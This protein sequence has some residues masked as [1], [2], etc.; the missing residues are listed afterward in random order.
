MA[1]LADATIIVEAGE[2]SGTRHQ[3]WEAIRLG[4]PVLFPKGFL[5]PSAPSWAEEMIS[6]GAFAFDRNT[7]PFVL[8]D[9]PYRSVESAAGSHELP[10]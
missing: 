2:T 4:R 3:G 9:L 1:L 10:F 6:Y 7:L 5:T 8:E